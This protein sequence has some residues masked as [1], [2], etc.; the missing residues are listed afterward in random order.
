MTRRITIL[1]DGQLCDAFI[2]FQQNIVK[3]EYDSATHFTAFNGV[4]TLYSLC[5]EGISIYDA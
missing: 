1:I 4:D 2:D 3:Y 5:I